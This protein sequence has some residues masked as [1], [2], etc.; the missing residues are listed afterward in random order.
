LLRHVL[1]RH[2]YFIMAWIV[3]TVVAFGFGPKL[4]ERLLQAAPPRPMLLRAH[5]TVFSGWVLLF[6]V[7]TGLVNL[8]KSAWYRRLGQVAA[9]LRCAITVL[10]AVAAVY[11]LVILGVLRDLA[12]RG[13]THPVYRVG[14]PAMAAAQSLAM[15]LF[16]AAPAW[17]VGAMRNLV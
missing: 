7:Q 15:Y 9:V 14:L 2:F 6:I 13:S 11:A 5:A 17:W 16:L 12:V 4:G 1:E 3:F 8:G 10:G